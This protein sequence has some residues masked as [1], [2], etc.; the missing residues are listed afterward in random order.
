MRSEFPTAPA[1]E[2]GDMMRHLTIMLVAASVVAPAFAGPAQDRILE[3]YLAESHRVDPSFSGFSAE[4]GRA[5]YISPHVGG[6]QDMPACATC[7]T[8]DPTRVGKHIKTGRE[9][10]PMAARI[11]TDRFTDPAKVEKRFSRDCPNVLGRECSAK[12]KGDFIFYL[13]NQ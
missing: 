11:T 4:R 10:E 9:I 2:S 3:T 1:K 6:Q 13:T 8:S 7:H 5:L 12:E